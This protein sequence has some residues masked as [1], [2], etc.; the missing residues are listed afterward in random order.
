MTYMSGFHSKTEG[1]NAHDNFH[2]I[3]MS[4]ARG[5]ENILIHAESRLLTTQEMAQI[6]RRPK[7]SIEW[8]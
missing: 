4:D 3:V 5:S 8:Q 1:G 6:L 7:S 2:R